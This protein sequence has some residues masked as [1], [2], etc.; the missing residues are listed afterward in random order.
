[1]K[2]K[3]IISVIT[4]EIVKNHS[5]TGT[6]EAS[7][8]ASSDLKLDLKLDSLDM[9]ELIYYLEDKYEISIP[10]NAVLRVNTVGELA[11]VVENF[12]K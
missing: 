2:K 6:S 7:I 9:V 3:E 4:Q 5:N 12:V 11:D 8:T 1:M 10:D